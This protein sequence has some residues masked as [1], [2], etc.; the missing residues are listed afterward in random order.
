M[1]GQD[2]KL[3]FLQPRSWLHSATWARQGISDEDAEQRLPVDNGGKLATVA[4]KK[5]L[6]QP[7][8]CDARNVGTYCNSQLF[9]HLEAMDQKLHFPFWDGQSVMTS[10]GKESVSVFLDR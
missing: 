10:N 6:L 8:M 3:Y 7:D 2:F 9:S 1:D 5:L 4:C